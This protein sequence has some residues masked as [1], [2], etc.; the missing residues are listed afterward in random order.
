MESFLIQTSK[1]FPMAGYYEIN[2][3]KCVKQSVVPIHQSNLIG[4]LILV[5]PSIWGDNAL[6][7]EYWKEKTYH[8]SLSKMKI[9]D[10]KKN[11]VF[12]GKI[13]NSGMTRC[14]WR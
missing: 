4:K 10:V 7:S 3:A 6:R 13:I 11:V 2:L 5:D 8:P 1:D 9:C 12:I 14:F